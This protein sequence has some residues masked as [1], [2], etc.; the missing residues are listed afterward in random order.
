[1]GRNW[2]KAKIIKAKLPSS[3]PK[4]KVS[5]NTSLIICCGL[6]GS[7]KSTFSEHLCSK[8][9]EWERA[10]TDLFGKDKRAVFDF[11]GRQSKNKSKKCI[12]ENCNVTI[13]KRKELLDCAFKPRD[14]VC[15]HF[16]IGK[17]ACIQRVKK[18]QNHETEQLFQSKKGNKIIDSFAK[19]FE[20]PTLK[21]GFA[22]IIT[23]QND[24]DMNALLA[25][26]GVNEPLIFA[27]QE[28]EEEEKKEQNMNLY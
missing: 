1:M 18:R 21:E 27:K 23:I 5:L 7:G 15:V 9:S 25:R 22:K 2:Q 17:S 14:A 13:S 28:E 12:V 11:I 8:R 19:Q 4:D 3:I 20:I 6:P 16:D 10:G 24:E 26:L